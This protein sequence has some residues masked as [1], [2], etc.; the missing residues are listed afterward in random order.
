MLNLLKDRP[1]VPSMIA[2]AQIIIE[3]LAKV[4]ASQGFLSTEDAATIA[5]AVVGLRQL[6]VMMNNPGFVPMK[7]EPYGFLRRQRQ[8]L[9]HPTELV[10]HN[11]VAAVEGLGASP[12]LTNAVCLL[13]AARDRV[14]DHLEGCRT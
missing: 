7:S 14:A 3:E 1:F 8:D 2:R 6:D 5:E 11:T 13:Q 9:F 12:A 10:L 4:V